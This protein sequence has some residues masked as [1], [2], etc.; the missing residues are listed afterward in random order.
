MQSTALG[1][2]T[3]RDRLLT[4][5][6]S[7]SPN[8]TVLSWQTAAKRDLKG[9]VPALA[10]PNLGKFVLFKAHF[11][12]WKHHGSFVLFPAKENNSTTKIRTQLFYILK[13]PMAEAQG[14]G[15]DVRGQPKVTGRIKWDPVCKAPQ[16]SS[17]FTARPGSVN[18][19]QKLVRLYL[20]WE[21]SKVP[22]NW[23]AFTVGS[24]G[25]RSEIC[26]PDFSHYAS[27]LRQDQW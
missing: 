27:K 7:T 15:R 25:S 16:Q 14:R 20:F 5:S 11:E 22:G 24:T 13:Q 6:M 3:Q 18:I 12:T 17:W 1:K 23:F 8:P 19:Q 2:E 4:V 26:S 9:I 21:G 10:F